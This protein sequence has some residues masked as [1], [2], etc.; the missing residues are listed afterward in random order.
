MRLASICTQML[1]SDPGDGHLI[2]VN[3]VEAFPLYPPQEVTGAV[4]VA[5]V[6]CPAC[7]RSMRY[8]LSASML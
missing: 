7:R 3:Q 2:Y 4:D 6:L 5:V 1:V 8:R